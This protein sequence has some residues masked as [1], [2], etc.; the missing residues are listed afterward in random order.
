M[1]VAQLA[2]LVL[3]LTP[4][5][6]LAADTVYVDHGKPERGAGNGD[7]IV[8]E[9]GVPDAKSAEHLY[10]THLAKALDATETFEGKYELDALV[11]DIVDPARRDGGRKKISTLDF[12]G[13]MTYVSPKMDGN[14]VKDE[15]GV[16]F[17]YLTAGAGTYAADLH[18]HFVEKL[19]AALK[20]KGLTLGDVFAPGAVIEFKVC[21]GAVD[22]KPLMDGLAERLPSSVRVKAYSKGYVWS[23]GANNFLWMHDRAYA[24]GL[25]GEWFGEHPRMAFQLG[26]QKDALVTFP[27]KFDEG[28]TPPPLSSVKLAPTATPPGPTTITNGTHELPTSRGILGR[29]R[30]Q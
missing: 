29:M 12:A 24:W 6:A 13:H 2:V 9:I 15:K 19:D 23:A 7:R 11:N 30:A 10:V 18:A 16:P 25:F 17:G 5:V 22:A 20:A 28:L 3:T 26:D 4:A 21:D 1:R 27:G 8:V 14:L